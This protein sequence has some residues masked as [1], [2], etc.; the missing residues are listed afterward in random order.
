MEART[1]GAAD[2][3]CPVDVGMSGSLVA[4]TGG[5]PGGGGCQL[6][7]RVPRCPTSAGSIESDFV[8][9]E[10]MQRRITKNTEG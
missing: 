6:G 5:A 7:I 9:L 8:L 10:T 1:G 4:M 3:K 2:M